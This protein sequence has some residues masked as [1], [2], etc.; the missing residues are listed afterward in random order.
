MTPR[1]LDRVAPN[2]TPKQ[3]ILTWIKEMQSHPSISEYARTVVELPPLRTV[4]GRIDESVRK[5]LAR[6]PNSVVLS[7]IRKA[8]REAAFLAGLAR[9]C[10]F[11]IIM[12][13]E[14]FRLKY[15]ILI[16]MMDNLRLRLEVDG[17]MGPV[18]FED[19][20]KWFALLHAD[21][22]G[23]Q[24]GVGTIERE[25]FDGHPILSADAAGLLEARLQMTE[26]MAPRLALDKDAVQ[27]SR[28][29]VAQG[30]VSRWV[31]MAKAEAHRA[32]GEETAAG[33]LA[34]LV[35]EC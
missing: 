35:M 16:F 20:Q 9:E 34:L 24:L 5:R 6:Q 4:Y 11:G 33:R 8:Q 19:L 25:Y 30:L 29:K 2:L 22:L 13:D 1:Q 18:E 21:S 7:A 12:A 14:A 17:M 32:M 15:A 27:K 3:A 10:T 23:H 31:Q 28:S 26:L